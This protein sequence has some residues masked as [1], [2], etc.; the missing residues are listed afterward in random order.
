MAK[1]K[2]AMAAVLV[3]ENEGVTQ[4]FGVPGAAI[5][6]HTMGG[7]P[8]RDR[9]SSQAAGPRAVNHVEVDS[10]SSSRC[11]QPCQPASCDWRVAISA[12]RSCSTVT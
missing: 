3:M 11:K 4:A 2:E 7:G 1:M 10:Q 6:P 12:M 5:N 8:S 9:P